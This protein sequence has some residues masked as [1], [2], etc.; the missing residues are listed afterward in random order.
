MEEA[1]KIAD[2]RRGQVRH[3]LR[4]LPHAARQ[5]HR[6]RRLER[7]VALL[8]SATDAATDA[9]ASSAT[10]A[11][12][13]RARTATPG[14]EIHH[15]MKEMIEGYGAID[16][17]SF[18]SVH[19]GKCVSATCRRRAQRGSV[20][21]GGNHTFKIIEP[22]V[23]QEAVPNPAHRDRRGD[24]TTHRCRGLLSCSASAPVTAGLLGRALTATVTLSETPC[25]STPRR[26]TTATKVHRSTETSGPGGDKALWLQDT[27]TASGVDQGKSTRSGRCS[28][29]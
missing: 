19:K 5:G 8:S 18:P 16:V 13:P 4:R 14:T 1:G 28:T 11:R 12:S 25:E 7:G 21:T 6:R 24:P 10:T 26:Q 20:Q 23:A 29:R 9:C 2:Q 27:S 17:S 3:H 22:E 15:P